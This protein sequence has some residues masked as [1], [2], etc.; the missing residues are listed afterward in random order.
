MLVLLAFSMLIGFGAASLVSLRLPGRKRE[1]AERV[2]GNAA[3]MLAGASVI[4]TAAW[5][6]PELR[7][8][9]NRHL[10]GMISEQG[11]GEAL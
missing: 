3:L 1:E 2:L 10:E 11:S 4:L 9:H 8:L 6:L 7:L 5:L